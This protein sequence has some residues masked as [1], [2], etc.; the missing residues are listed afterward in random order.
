MSTQTVNLS[1]I[2]RLGLEALT[3]ALGPVGMVRFIHQFE[4]GAGDYTKERA[5]WFKELDTKKIAQ[6]IKGMRRRQAK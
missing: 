2:R 4:T 5:Q 1:A 6:E 3:K